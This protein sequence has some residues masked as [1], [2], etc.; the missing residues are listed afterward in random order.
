MARY[1][2]GGGKTDLKIFV[3]YVM[4]HVP[5]PVTFD[6]MSE[7]VLIDD[8]INYF[9]YCECVAELLEGGLM[10]KETAENGRETYRIT[11]RGGETGRIVESS[12]PFS[13]RRA[14][15]ETVLI[16]L[17]RIQ[18]H[19]RLEAH[20]IER[21]G[22]PLASLKM[23]DGRDAILQMELM[24]GSHAQAR[25]ICGNFLL[26]AEHI[27]DR[28]LRSLLTPYDDGEEAAEEARS[29]RVEWPDDRPD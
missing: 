2:F 15:K 10:R 3:L 6:Q 21:D 17:N 28:V 9:L 18:R 4:R 5:D 1:G 26:H 7:M 11:P 20:V 22:E 14:A 19:A 12:V 24:T 8:N 29:G 23:T 16:V 25:E 27:V 13:L